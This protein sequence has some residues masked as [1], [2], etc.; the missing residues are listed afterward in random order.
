MNEEERVITNYELEEDGVM[1]NS[2]RP[3][4]LEEYVGQSDVK[5]NIKVFIEAAKIRKEPLDHVLLYGPP[6]LGKT[7]LAFIIAHELGSNIKTASGPSIEKAGD[8]AAILSTLEPGDVL[9]IDEIHRMPRFIEEILY[10]AMED[11]SLD[12]IVGGDG[13]N[14]SIKIDLP[15]FT[16]VGAT[17]R[18]GDLSGP[19]RD[20]FGIVSKLQFYTVDELKLII[21]RTSRVLEMKITEEAALELASRSRGT[22]R[23]A[24][25]LFKRVRDFA[26]VDQSDIIDLNITK[27]ALQ[28]LKVDEMGLDDTDYQ[29]LKAII[30]KF[31]GGPVGVEALASAIGEEVSTIEDVYEPYLLQNG[32]LKRTSRGRMVTE[33]AYAHLHI[34]HQA[35]MFD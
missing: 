12:I 14:R 33:K 4:T 5:E 21:E 6:G 25:R 2:I 30:E 9:F 24:N 15:P 23:I 13:N 3:E 28:R 22:P 18:A 27:K 26:L 7:T 11:F 1:D 32:L 31:N 34:T 10:P 35:N 29:L 16:L 17:T 19:L 20:R 8:L